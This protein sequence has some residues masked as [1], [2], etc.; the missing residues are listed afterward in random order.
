MDVN[1]FMSGIDCED[2][3]WDLEVYIPKPNFDSQLFKESVYAF[4]WKES[5]SVET[6]LQIANAARKQWNQT[7]LAVEETAA[8]LALQKSCRESDRHRE[9]TQMKDK[10]FI[11]WEVASEKALL[12]VSCPE[13]EHDEDNSNEGDSYHEIKS[14]LYG[15]DCI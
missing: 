6:A 2:W 11:V 1:I 13:E 5:F 9:L 3:F 12:I 4:F 14:R 8:D 15:P 7:D 10:L